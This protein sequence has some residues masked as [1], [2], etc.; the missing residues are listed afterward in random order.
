MDRGPSHEQKREWSD[1]AHGPQDRLRHGGRYFLPTIQLEHFT[2][3]IGPALRGEKFGC[4]GLEHRDAAQHLHEATLRHGLNR[5]PAACQT[6]EGG[7]RQ[8]EPD[9]LNQAQG[10]RRDRH[11]RRATDQV[12]AVGDEEQRIEQ[13]SEQIIGQDLPHGQI[14]G[15]PKQQVTARSLSEP[16]VGE[17]HEMAQDTDHQLFVQCGPKPGE[18]RRAQEANRDRGQA[19]RDHADREQLD[20]RQRTL[21]RQRINQTLHEQGQSQTE[22]LQRQRGDN[23]GKEVGASVLQD[24]P[25]AGQHGIRRAIHVLDP[26]R[27]QVKDHAGRVRRKL[28]AT[29]AASADRRI[30]VLDEPAH[31]PFEDD[32]VVSLP[33]DDRRHD[34]AAHRLRRRSAC[35]HFESEQLGGTLQ[36]EGADAVAVPPAS[37]ATLREAP[38]AAVKPVEHG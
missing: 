35:L 23:D 4:A 32:K 33:V 25:A 36:G 1:C 30:D 28:T 37:L 27:S 12:D 8:E 10:Q 34:Q 29:H 18:E 26:S 5:R 7:A 9:R 17:L 21:P 38:L 15:E 13:E 2:E 11:D 14:A 3:A 24:L 22:C 16:A 19:D 6:L 31:G 20:R